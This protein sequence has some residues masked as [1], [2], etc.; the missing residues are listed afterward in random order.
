MTLTLADVDY[1]RALNR[2][3]LRANIKK[4]TKHVAAIQL[5]L[6]LTSL[7]LIMREA[8]AKAIKR[9][10]ACIKLMQGIVLDLDKCTLT[11]P[12]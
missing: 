7:S 4:T 3:Q 5:Q 10:T 12:R 9:H 8:S 2:T 1:Y 6:E 11:R